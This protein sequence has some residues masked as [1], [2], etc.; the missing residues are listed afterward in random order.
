MKIKLLL[1]ILTCS[2]LAVAAP[3]ASVPPEYA[4]FYNAQQ[5]A[6]A[7][8]AMNAPSVTPHQVDTAGVRK[9]MSGMPGLNGEINGRN[10]YAEMTPQQREARDNLIRQRLQE[11]ARRFGQ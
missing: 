10:V 8:R 3:P 9:L 2:T 6:D 5:F 11:T 4:K 7:A 1:L